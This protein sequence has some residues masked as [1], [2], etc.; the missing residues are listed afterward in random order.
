MY[1][2]IGKILT[3]PEDII[4]EVASYFIQKISKKDTRRVR[5]ERL[6][7][8]RRFSVTEG[9]YYD[10]EFRYKIFS[11]N[12]EITKIYFMIRALPKHFIEYIFFCENR[13]NSIRFW[14]TEDKCEVA[15]DG[16]WVV[17]PSV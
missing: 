16:Y 17:K 7:Y 1:N 8:E 10:G 2:I 6:L 9:F 4:R 3:L 5:I 15:V 11:P 14:I 13:T 12:L